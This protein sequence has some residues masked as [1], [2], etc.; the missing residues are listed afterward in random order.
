MLT[1]EKDRQQIESVIIINRL[2]KKITIIEKS[3]RKSKNRGVLE[4]RERN[5][6]VTLSLVQS[7]SVGI[8]RAVN[9]KIDLIWYQSTSI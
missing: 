1:L 5:L 2:R 7:H 6:K 3:T 8:V 9:L 4:K